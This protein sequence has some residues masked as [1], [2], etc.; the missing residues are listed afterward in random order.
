MKRPPRDPKH[1]KLVNNRLLCFTYLQIGVIQS[2]AG[3]ITYFV[4]MAENGFLPY[5]LINIRKNWDD[6]NID[7]IMDSYGQQW[8]SAGVRRCA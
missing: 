7:D 6:H 8:V 2:L 5:S 3:F 4:V 1:D